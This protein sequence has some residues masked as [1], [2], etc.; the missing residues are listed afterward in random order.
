MT[1]T[2]YERGVE[3]GQREKFDAIYQMVR[4]AQADA[5]SE[6]YAAGL[7]PV[8]TVNPYYRKE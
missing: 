6:G 3:D 7:V 4:K 2:D 8:V 1:T 5:W